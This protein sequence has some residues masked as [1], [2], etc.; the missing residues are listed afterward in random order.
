MLASL[1][2]LLRDLSVCNVLSHQY[3]RMLPSWFYWTKQHVTSRSVGTCM[4]A[5]G[6]Q[7]DQ[8]LGGYGVQRRNA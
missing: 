3:T 1:L 4:E 5:V 7:I 8:G 2:W 6:P